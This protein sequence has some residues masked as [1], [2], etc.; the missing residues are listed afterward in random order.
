M[1]TVAIFISKMINQIL[2]ECFVLSKRKTF[3]PDLSFLQIKYQYIH[4]VI[5]L[6]QKLEH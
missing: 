1:E 5:F 3:L 2:D 4:F 6:F